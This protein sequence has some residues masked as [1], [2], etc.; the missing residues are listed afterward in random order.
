LHAK[1]QLASRLSTVRASPLPYEGTGLQ[2]QLPANLCGSN[3]GYMPYYGAGGER[4]VESLI[5]SR[6]GRVQGPGKSAYRTSGIR[7]CEFGRL[8]A[9]CLV[10]LC[11][12]HREAGDEAEECGARWAR[13]LALVGGCAFACAIARGGRSFA[14]RMR[15]LRSSMVSTRRSASRMSR[16][17]LSFC[18]SAGAGANSVVYCIEGVCQCRSCRTLW[19]ISRRW[20]AA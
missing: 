11:G 17:S 4:C 12:T 7:A 2:L 18:V 13:R 14:A 6:C 19:C 8:A 5:R 15:A 3:C 1:G 20:S 10:D 9:R 16:R